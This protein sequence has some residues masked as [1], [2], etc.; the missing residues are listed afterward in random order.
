MPQALGEDLFRKIEGLSTWTG[1]VQVVLTAS[2]A[3]MKKPLVILEPFLEQMGAGL[4]TSKKCRLMGR[5]FH[6][7]SRQLFVKAAVMESHDP[8]RD[9]ARPLRE[10][11]RHF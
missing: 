8:R 1:F 5:Q 11:K 4:W 2:A 7:W 10:L 9:A 6:R 3:Y